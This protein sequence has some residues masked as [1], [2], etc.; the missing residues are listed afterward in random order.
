MTPTWECP[1]ESTGG[2]VFL[3]V[4]EFGKAG[5]FLK[6]GEVLVVARMIAILRAKLDGDLEILERGV[7][8]SGETIESGQGV[9]NVVGFGRGFASFIEAFACIIPAPD[10]HHGHAALIVLVGSAGI[11]L[12]RGLHALVGNLEVHAGAV[13]ELFTWTFQNL[14]E[15]LFGASEL[16]LMEKGQGFI[17]E[18]QLGLHAGIDHFHPAALGR[19]RWR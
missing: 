12:V 2:A 16:L 7:G 1:R 14:L 10:V 4:Q 17:V 6:E 5:I 8:F 9:V 19:V 13:G 11:L 15:L 3:G 18:F